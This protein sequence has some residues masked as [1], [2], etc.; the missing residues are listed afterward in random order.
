VGTPREAP[1]AEMPTTCGTVT[2]GSWPNN[3]IGEDTAVEIRFGFELDTVPAVVAQ[4]SA[5]DAASPN[6]KCVE[7]WTSDVSRN[8][9]RLH[10][11]TWD[12]ATT[13]G[14]TATWVATTEHALVQVGTLP[15]DGFVDSPGAGA[16]ALAA[17][18]PRPFACTPDVVFGLSALHVGA[19]GPVHFLLDSMAP[20]PRTWGLRRSEP[21]PEVVRRASVSWIASASPADLQSGMAELGSHEA[22]VHGGDAR[23]EDVRFGKTFDGVP[24]VTVAIAGLDADGARPTRLRAWAEDVTQDGFKLKVCTWEDSV[25]FRVRI[26]WVATPMAPCAT[27]VAIPPHQPPARYIV[28]GPPLGHG[29]CAVTHRARNRDDGMIYAVKTSRYPFGQNQRALTQ[30]LHNLRRLPLHCNLLQFHESILEADRLHIVTDFVDAMRFADILPAPCGPYKQRHAATTLLKW[31]AQ[32]FDGLGALHSVGLVHRDLHCENVLV[33]RAPDGTPSEGMRAVRIIDFGAAGSYGL[34][35]SALAV[36]ATAPRLMSQVAGWPQYFSPERRIGAPFDDRDDVWAAGCHLMELASGRSIRKLEGCGADGIEFSTT[37]GAAADVLRHCP[38]SR[39]RELA[40][41]ALAECRDLRPRAVAVR[42]HARRLLG[43][44]AG[45]KRGRSGRSGAAGGMSAVTNCSPTAS[46]ARSPAS[47]CK[48]LR[49]QVAQRFA[50]MMPR[51]G[52]TP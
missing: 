26:S 8:G 33:E 6:S 3:S 7:V 11:R 24:S 12:D 46:S 21:M 48:R 51:R 20:R 9:F 38:D 22:P 14:I 19:N 50:S 49:L 42:D 2:L 43:A 1:R 44:V 47:G 13:Y 15:L 16:E 5:I 41:F 18:F 34:S 25:T 45:S 37:P 28:D 29:F 17:D 39:C 32:L 10:A 27:T 23:E 40:G 36:A 4:L 52:A 31:G 35:T 30:E